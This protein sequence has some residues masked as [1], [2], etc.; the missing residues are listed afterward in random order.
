MTFTR[1]FASR[2]RQLRYCSK[3]RIRPTPHLRAGDEADLRIVDLTPSN[4]ARVRQLADH[5]GGLA[6]RLTTAADA[7]KLLGLAI[8]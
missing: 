4:A 2:Q 8:A 7:R 6:R 1:R 5:M 3:L